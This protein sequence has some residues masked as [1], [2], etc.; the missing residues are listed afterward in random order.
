[1]LPVVRERLGHAVQLRW[2]RFPSGI[3]IID[4]LQLHG[5]A[6]RPAHYGQNDAIDVTRGDRRGQE[7]VCR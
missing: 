3:D 7:Y 2:L 5:S 4:K 6:M 1:M